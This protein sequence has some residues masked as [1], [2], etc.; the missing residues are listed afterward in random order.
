MDNF[1]TKYGLLIEIQSNVLCRCKKFIYVFYIIECTDILN[2]T[3]TRG[4][5]NC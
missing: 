2:N 4:E 1:A 3:H 5:L